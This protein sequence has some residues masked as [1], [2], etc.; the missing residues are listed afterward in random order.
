MR[1]SFGRHKLNMCK[2][3]NIEGP[4]KKLY[5]NKREINFNYQKTI[6]QITQPSEDIVSSDMIL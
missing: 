6:E 4:F 3:I 1:V 5:E 2:Q